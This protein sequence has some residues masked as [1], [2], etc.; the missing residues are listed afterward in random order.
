MEYS[1][2]IVTKWTEQ[3]LLHNARLLQATLFSTSSMPEI[4]WEPTGTTLIMEFVPV[5]IHLLVTERPQAQYCDGLRGP[6][7][8]YD[9]DDPY[10]FLY[11]VDDGT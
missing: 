2:A 6:L 1:N 8:I 3:R 5:F 4:K 7:I 11:D 9:H 10:R